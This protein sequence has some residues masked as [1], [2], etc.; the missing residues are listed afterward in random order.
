MS[1]AAATTAAA[2]PPPSSSTEA[3]AN[4]AEPANVVADM[5]MG[6]TNPMPVGPGQH[7]KRDAEG[8]E[9]HGQRKSGPGA[10]THGR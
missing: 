8:D 4:W 9:D 7:A 10:C 5:T 6:D 1:K 3:T 2:M